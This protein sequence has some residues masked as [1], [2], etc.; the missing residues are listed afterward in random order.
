MSS[1]PTSEEINQLSRVKNTEKC[2]SKWLRMDN[3]FNKEANLMKHINQY[4]TSESVYNYYA[5]L[6]RYLKEEFII[7]LCKIWDQY[8]FPL[9][10]KTLDDK[11]K[12]LQI[13][14][15]GKTI[16]ADSLAK[17][18]LK[19]ILDHSFMNGDNNES[20]IRRVFFWILLLCG[21]RGGDVYKIEDRQITR[22]NDCGLNLEMFIEKNNQRGVR[23][24]NKYGKS[25]SR[26]IPIPPDLEGNI[27]RPIYDIL[28][29]KS[30]RPSNACSSF[31]LETTRSKKDLNEKIWYKTQRMGQNKLGKMLYQIANLTAIQMLR[32][33]DIPVDEIMEFSSHRSR[34]GVRTYKS[35]DEA[36]KIQNIV[37]LIPLD[38]EDI[39]VE[40]FEYFPGN[41][42][43][44]FN[45]ND[46]SSDSESSES[47]KEEYSSPSRDILKSSEESTNENSDSNIN[48]NSSNKNNNAKRREKSKNI[49]NAKQFSQRKKRK[50]ELDTQN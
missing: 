46:Y 18:K 23:N 2:T 35:L 38:I 27:Y 24:R 43:T 16:Q 12:Q 48:T 42:R 11:M 37:S 20:L 22:R 19:Q 30:M 13:Q 15:L 17:Q 9:V 28:K 49:S 10:I 8:T 45:Y 32:D 50:S 39:E 33:E 26:K 4:D 6:A 21:L 7:R 5:S 41:S 25:T 40:E 29:Y 34:E 1:I 31:F 14:G 3:K 36:R 47:N 44:N